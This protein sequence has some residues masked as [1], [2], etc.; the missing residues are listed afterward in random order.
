MQKMTSP[1]LLSTYGAG[2]LGLG[3]L[4]LFNPSPAQAGF[5]G[6]FY[7]I[8]AQTNKCLISPGPGDNVIS[9]QHD[10]VEYSR[11][12]GW[13]I[14][15]VRDGEY[16]IKNLHSGKC[17]TIAGG[18]STENNVRA[19]QYECD[20]DPS[21]RWQLWDGGSGLYQI[22]NVQTRKCLTI[23]G[24]RSTDRG[25]EALQY[26]CDDDRSR[27]WQLDTFRLRKIKKPSQDTTVP[28]GKPQKLDDN[29]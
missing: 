22:I 26:D 7:M 10:C 13:R 16:Q 25:V 20:D 14:T 17:L 1:R 8:N 24:G 27:R 21:R 29:Y 9:V 12:R 11:L 2:L 3:V 18:R 28:L 5:D 19:L 6:R 23:A 15:E 4:F